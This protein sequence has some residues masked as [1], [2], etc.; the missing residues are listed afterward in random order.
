MKLRR[1][2]SH[3]FQRLFQASKFLVLRRQIYP[4]SEFLQIAQG[5][6]KREKGKRNVCNCLCQW[7]INTVFVITFTYLSK[8]VKSYDR[9]EIRKT[10]E[11][12]P[13]T[14]NRDVNYWL[15][16]YLFYVFEKS[17][18][19]TVTQCNL[20]DKKLKGEKTTKPRRLKRRQGI[21]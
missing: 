8:R 12:L 3:S 14:I 19:R 13:I 4:W 18:I 16:I 15:L 11:T 17:I 7:Q 9:F 20:E 2:S 1:Y 10:E 6:Q 5:S 21:C